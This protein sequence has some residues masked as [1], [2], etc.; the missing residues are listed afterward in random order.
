MV[1]GKTYFLDR[2]LQ[3]TTH[4]AYHILSQ[5]TNYSEFLKL[6]EGLTTNV[7]DKAGLYDSLKAKKLD[8]AAGKEREKVAL[9][10]YIFVAGNKAG[11]VFNAGSKD[12]KLVRFFNNYRYTIYAPTNDAITAEV[13]KG[14]PTWE[15]IEKYLTDNLQAEVQLAEDKSNQKRIWCCKQAQYWN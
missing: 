13:A 14:L 11:Q 5:N 12:D 3:A 10:Y 7:L 1:N 4:T 2:P 6:C 9:K 15:S 8:D